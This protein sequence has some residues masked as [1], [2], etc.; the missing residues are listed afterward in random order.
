VVANGVAYIGA[1]DGKLYAFAVG[2]AAGGGIC[3]PLW[4][5]ATGDSIHSSP[6]VANGVVYIGSDDGKLYA[7]DAAGV[8]GCSGSPKTCAP[9]WTGATGW[10]VT[11]SPAVA[12]GVVYVGSNDYKLYAFDAAGVT[13]CSGSPKTC[14]PL[15]TGAT[16]SVV[17][18]S[19]AVANG[20]VYV[21]SNDYK[22]YA[23]DA[24]G[25]TGCSGS[26]KT[27][28][29]LWTGATGSWIGYAS[30]AVADGVV[31]IG[32]TD[33]KLYAFD[34]AGVTG[35]S[36]S[37]KTCAPLWTGSTTDI[38]FSSPAV[39]N[40]VVYVG[41]N[42]G[43]LYAF[44]AT[45]VTGCNGSPKTCTPLWTGAT[46]S[47]IEDSPA[48]A[49][50]V[51]YIGSDDNKLYAFD[52]A[53]ATGCSGSP[54]TCTPLWT[55]ATGNYI[56]FSSPAVANGVV[57][58]G[59]D[60]NKLHAFS[61]QVAPTGAT[62]H[63]LT[64]TRILDSRDHT[65]GLGIFSSHVAQTFAV[66]GH[67]GVPAGATAVT[68]NLTVTQQTSA[69]FLYIGPVAANNPT[70]ST[71]NF[72]LGDDRANAVTVALGTGGTLSVTYAA[73]TLGPTAQ[74]IFDV[75]GYFTPDASGATYHALTPSRILD[76]RD[77]TGGLGIFSSHG[78]QTFLVRGVG[79]VPASATAVTGNLTVTGQSSAGF[80]YI[81][82]VGM[83]NPTSSTLNFPLGDDRANAV[84]VALGGGG[85]LSVTYAA[86]TLGPTAQVIFDVTGYFTPD[87]TGA[88]Y[89][90]L[91]PARILDTRDHTGGLGIF[92]SHVAQSF[93]VTGHGGVAAGATA[94]TGNLTVTQQSSAGFLSVGPV[95]QNNPTS[96]TLNF[97]LADDRANAVTV[98][99]G[100]GGTLSVTY[101]AGTLG[102]T[103]QVIFDVTGY[104]AP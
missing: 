44:D 90:P 81:G 104:F 19:P 29:P 79:G 78:A 98:A 64:P 22:L 32:S 25:V 102:P 70:S 38:I 75:T 71:L 89:V 58:V 14:T 42:D 24:A 83:A 52:A 96:S 1:H 16:G 9:L 72:P 80:L 18:S 60:D 68:G 11:S 66:T 20:V 91:T 55:G 69:G 13:G 88:T 37:P 85:T 40:G 54:K 63:A 103:A 86:A 84:T 2:C 43:K 21:G 97:P 94:V 95:A 77:H 101:A 100:T 87:L 99:L 62:Y 33:G 48:V 49:N 56:R 36:G 57:Y 12:N 74:V 53:G 35:C 82:P 92:S 61:L 23:F 45:G 15:W 39:A 67:G 4:T 6:A 93:T 76:S 46:G 73:S 27:C 8:T 30:P 65:G 3:A 28:T 7:F 5:G 50:G 34:A 47:Y 10:G 51:V 59:S 17:T 31:Y 41:S 26:P